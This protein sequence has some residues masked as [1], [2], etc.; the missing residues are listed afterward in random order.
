MESICHDDAIMRPY[1]D[2][3]I[4]VLY[5]L[6]GHFGADDL[7]SASVEFN[8]CFVSLNF[9]SMMI[10]SCDHDPHARY[11]NTVEKIP[12]IHVKTPIIA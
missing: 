1:F 6:L 3:Q 7:L 2:G 12:R 10:F 9:A 11:N 8:Y 4:F 5:S